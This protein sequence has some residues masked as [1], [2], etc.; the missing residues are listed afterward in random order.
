MEHLN[1]MIRVA[2]DENNPSVARIEENVLNAVNVQECAMTLLALTTTMIW[3][4][5]VAN[6]YV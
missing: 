5:L 2:I 6:L 1:Q 4:Q 3:L